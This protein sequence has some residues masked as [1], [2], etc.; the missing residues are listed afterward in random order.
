MGVQGFERLPHSSKIALPDQPYSYLRK[1]C[2]CPS[3]PHPLLRHVADSQARSV[4]R[5]T[6]PGI[7]SRKCGRCWAM[8]RRRWK[9]KGATAQAH[10]DKMF[11]VLTHHSGQMAADSTSRIVVQDFP[12]LSKAGHDLLSQLLTYDPEQRIS[13]TCALRHPWLAEA[14]FPL[15]C[16]AMPHFSSTH[17]DGGGDRRRRDGARCAPV[18]SLTPSPRRPQPPA[19]PPPSEYPGAHGHSRMQAKHQYWRRSLRRIRTYARCGVLGGMLCECHVLCSAR[20]EDAKRRHEQAGADSRFGATFGAS[21]RPG[22]RQ[23]R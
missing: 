8:G 7:I 22:K 16:A 13:A 12:A 5:R 10:I 6:Q 20:H 1:V 21:A 23:A 19:T 11:G 17:I 2:R 15:D 14:P 3:A 9:A 18:C 4:R